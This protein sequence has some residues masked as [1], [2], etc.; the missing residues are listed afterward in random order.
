MANA[1]DTVTATRGLCSACKHETGCIYPRSKEEI[2]F[3][4][5]QFDPCLPITRP[6]PTQDQVELE[7]L[8]RKPS[9]QESEAKFTGL[10]S[11][12][13]DRNVC[14]YPKPAGGVWRCEEY[15]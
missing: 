8:W 11:S 9:S 2:V 13:E 4:C 15:R 12:C 6:R 1:I 7:R 5:G 14:I 3:N 10:C